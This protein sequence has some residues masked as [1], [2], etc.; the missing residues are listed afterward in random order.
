M[1]YPLA[2]DDERELLI[3]RLWKLRFAIPGAK[4]MELQ[5]LR[6]YVAYCEARVKQDDEVQARAG[7]EKVA[8]MSPAQVAGALKEYIAYKRNRMGLGPRQP[9]E[10]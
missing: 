4:D 1:P 3:N 7:A 10:G 8:Q 9:L 2:Q 5:Q 6:D